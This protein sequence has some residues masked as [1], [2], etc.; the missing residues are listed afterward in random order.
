[1]KFFSRHPKAHSWRQTVVW[2]PVEI[3]N[4][5]QSPIRLMATYPPRRRPQRHRAFRRY[6]AFKRRWIIEMDQPVTGVRR[7]TVLVTLENQQVQPPVTFQMS[8]VRP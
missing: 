6:R 7:I 5:Q 4:I 3:R 1:M 8:M 2:T